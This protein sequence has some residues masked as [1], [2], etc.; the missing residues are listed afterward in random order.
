MTVSLNDVY[1]EA[2]RVYDN[3][4]CLAIDEKTK[5]VT[6]TTDVGSVPY[7]TST[8]VYQ[9]VEAAHAALLAL[10]DHPRVLP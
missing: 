4:F 8:F 9:S 6:L 1:A 5:H 10:R 7:N 3:R 2:R